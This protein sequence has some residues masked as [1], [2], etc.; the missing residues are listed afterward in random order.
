MTSITLP[1]GFISAPAVHALAETQ[2][3]VVR[4]EQL[5]AIGVPAHTIRYML[6]TGRWRSDAGGLVVVLHNGPLEVEQAESLAVLAGGR[7][8][9]LAART[10]A[11]RA[12]LANWPSPRVEIVIPR[13]STYPLVSLGDVKVHE[14]RR[15][16]AED[17]H[18]A[19]FPPRV[20]LTR[21]VVDAASW[22]RTPRATCG[23]LA[24]AVQQ[25]LC[26]A[27]QLLAEL[28]RAGAIRRARLMRTALADIEGGAHAMTEIDFVRFCVRNGLP[29]PLHQQ[30]RR[31]ASGR[32]RYLDATLR[33]PTGVEVRVEIDGALHL[34]VETYWDDMQRSNDL[35]IGREVALRFPSYV[36]YADDP[37]AV[38]Q[39]RAALKLNL[40]P[41]ATSANAWAS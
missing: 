36:I 38:A 30:V 32:R 12:G 1:D 28:D 24:A 35:A 6:T 9:A 15:F 14:S 13:G 3:C 26:T 10:A 19:S 39:L 7:V 16:S 37:A 5:T 18:P 29:R 8:C 23:L 17:I 11:A 4:R 27:G 40:S 22:S 31:D 33:G 2:R 20:R 21:A 41:P 25:R 34:V